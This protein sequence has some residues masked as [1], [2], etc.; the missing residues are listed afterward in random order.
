M[1]T[2]SN[3]EK[4]KM[5]LKITD[6]IQEL[7]NLLNEICIDEQRFLFLDKKQIL[8]KKN[9]VLKEYL[10]KRKE[11]KQYLPDIN[12]LIMNNTIYVV[13][14]IHANVQNPRQ[15]MKIPESMTLF[16]FMTSDYGT[17]SCPHKERREYV[18]HVLDFHT[19]YRKTKYT[20][21]NNIKFFKMLMKEIIQPL[22]ESIDMRISELHKVTQK[23]DFTK[24]DLMGIGYG[25]VSVKNAKKF[26]NANK[27]IHIH[28][29]I[30]SSKKLVKK[31]Y[32]INLDFANDWNQINV[33]NSKY[34][35]IN[36]VDY[37]DAT[38][39]GKSW[40]KI[41][42][43]DIFDLFK[44]V[45]YVFLLDFSCSDTNNNDF[46]Q[47]GQN[48]EGNSITQEIQNYNNSSPY[49]ILNEDEQKAEDARL[50]LLEIAAQKRAIEKAELNFDKGYNNLMKSRNPFWRN[51]PAKNY[52]ENVTNKSWLRRALRFT[53]KLYN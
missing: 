26:T 18:K 44:H 15:S 8:D 14:D 34:P 48:T 37:V 49:N 6:E 29:F 30:D 50:K 36:L 12:D 5:R 4:E 35:R 22:Q 41:N 27:L 53:R 24:K 25:S 3:A 2:L 51:S 31:E 19:Q 43:K 46:K 52:N 1:A 47:F 33:I 23:K 21:R 16:K 17:I 40:L 42:M 32:Y 11:I 28:G 9:E 45:P 39:L 38:L 20:K 13:F 10:A 7:S